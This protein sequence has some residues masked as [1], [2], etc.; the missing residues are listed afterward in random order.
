MKAENIKH[1]ELKVSVVVPVLDGAGTIGDTLTAL[2]NQVGVPRAMEIIVV[3]NGSTD[4]T[5]EIVRRYPVCLLSEAKRGAAAA[6]NCGLFEARGEVVA[7]LDADTLPTRR[8]LA[9][10]TAPFADASV[11]ITGGQVLD[12]PPQTAP[13]RFMAQAGT[14]RLEYDFFRKDF[15]YVGAGNMAVRRSAALA[16]DGCDETL[17]TAED[18]DFCVRLV[19]RFECPIVRQP[20]AILLNRHRMTDDALRRQAWMYG[21]GHAQIHLRYPDIVRLSLSRWMYVAWTLGVRGVKSMLAAPGRR[22]GLTSEA[23]A[24]FA[25][26]H[27]FWSWWFWRGFISMLR[28]R[29]W[30][31]PEDDNR[32]QN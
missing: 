17:L 14:F 15:A 11:L 23:R 24:E 5:R 26:Y 22:L 27:W 10:L 18:Q 19:R 6:R 9:E 28:F 2:A 12:Y 30:H 16:I 31:A 32:F 20:N 8:W 7:F 4:G 1:G 21:A 25:R 13:E 29:E 3:D